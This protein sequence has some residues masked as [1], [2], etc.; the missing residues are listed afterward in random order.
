MYLG[1][2]VVERLENQN[3]GMSQKLPKGFCWTLP[4][5]ASKSLLTPWDAIQ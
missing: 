4:G 1:D 2:R 3:D 5:R